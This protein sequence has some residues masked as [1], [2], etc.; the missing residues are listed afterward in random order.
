MK[1]STAWVAL[2][3]MLYQIMERNISLI[4]KIFKTA[5]LKISHNTYLNDEIKQL[6]LSMDF[7]ETVLLDYDKIC[8]FRPLLGAHAS[9]MC[10]EGD[11]V[12]RVD[13]EEMMV[14]SRIWGISSEGSVKKAQ[15]AMG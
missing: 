15:V 13:F 7:Y 1:G 3:G 8:P 12:F 14:Y 11:L 6:R 4:E 9:S 5:L 2:D 10:K